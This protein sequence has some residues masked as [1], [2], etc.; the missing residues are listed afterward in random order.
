MIF[1]WG[2]APAAAVPAA[3]T[4]GAAGDAGATDAPGAGALAAGADCSRAV[5]GDVC[6]AAPTSCKRGTEKDRLTCES[7]TDSQNL[8][9]NLVA[10]DSNQLLAAGTPP[11][12]VCMYG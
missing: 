5:G 6:L 3:A 10:K 7:R 2:A 12:D 11:Q 9:Q 4:A 1:S 8:S